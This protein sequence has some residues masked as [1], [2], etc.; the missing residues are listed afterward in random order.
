MRTLSSRISGHA[1]E[2]RHIRRLTTWKGGRDRTCPT[3]K[4]KK[5]DADKQNRK[6]RRKVTITAERGTYVC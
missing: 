2:I 3:P 4:K 6:I 5:T 1:G